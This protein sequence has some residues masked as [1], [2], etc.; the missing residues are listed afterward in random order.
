MRLP[1]LAPCASLLALSLAFTPAC[2]KSKSQ[3]DNQ[4]KTP[5]TAAATAVQTGDDMNKQPKQGADPAR[6]NAFVSAQVELLKPLQIEAGKSWYAASIS[7]S[8]EDFAA[9]EKADNALNAFKAD[10]ERFAEVRALRE[11]GPSGDALA[12]RQL[13]LLYLGMLGKQVDEAM[14]T[15]ITALEK[16][17]EK[18]FNTYRAT[19]DGKPASQ[20]DIE[21]VL[22]ESKD[23]A[24]L[25]AAWEGQKGVGPEVAP[26]LLELVGLRN[27]VAQKLGFRDFYAMRLAESELDEEELLAL[28][29]KLDELTREPFLK[30]KADV[31]AR[32]AK[33]L[34]VAQD[35][36][37]PWHYQNP[38]FQEPPGVFDTGLDALYKKQDVVALSS[39]FF[40]GIGLAAD[41]I[42]A[43][44]DLY[45]K[46]G[47]SPHAF[48]I[49]ID[50]EGDVR[51]LCNVVPGFNWQST[52][53]HELGH[54]VYDKYT[55]RDLPWL[56]REATHPLTTEGIA[57][58]FDY[59]VSNP[60]WPEAM[61]LMD[62]KT[63]AAAMDEAR[64]FQA[65][66]ELQ[67]SRWTQV[68]LRFEREM[69]RDPTQDLNTL[70]WDLVERY[71]GLRRPPGRNAPDYASKIH[72]VVAPVYY[73]NYMLGKLFAAQVHEAIAAHVGKKPEELVYVN[74]PR[75]GTFLVDKVFGPGARYDWN[76][77]TRHATGKDL[78]PDAFARRF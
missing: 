22:A 55:A 25:Q 6:V 13:E 46:P 54:A 9:S 38:F 15:K 52:M 33:R 41:D 76:E 23:S 27:Q 36:L 44:S 31:D 7:G 71:Q 59:L 51:V 12:D 67:F 48:A 30:A 68:M 53:V 78:A 42:V 74:D 24:K 75:V 60:M 62:E 47:K 61:G 32:L 1:S 16:E 14:L 19:L 20:N 11:A 2:S 65:F 10:S 70:W 63:R 8:D 72:L 66:A 45:E 43:R 40:D 37:M 34:G 17:V 26:R 4:D 49:D 50:R 73:Q 69:Y 29:D 58:M 77:L 18:L 39:K 3:S 5:A 28:F 57:M 56:L 64:A 35:Q 21:A